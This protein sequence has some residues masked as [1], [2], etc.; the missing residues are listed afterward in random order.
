MIPH[1]PWTIKDSRDPYVDP[2]IKV[3]LDAV[4][5]PDGKD[6]QHVVVTMK[7][8]V[9]VLALDDDN[10]VYLTSEFH[11]GVGRYSLEAVSGGI[12]PGEDADLTAQRELQEEIG[13]AAKNW[14]YVTTVDP[15]TTIVVSPTRLY[16]AT[17]LADAP[18]NPEGT[19]LIETVKMPLDEAIAKVNCGE[20]SHAPTC[21]ILMHAKLKQLQS[22]LVSS[23]Q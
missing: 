8:G 22:M 3:R 12:E 18:K 23:S 11:Y 10:N 9:C 21:V 4:I 5:R 20:I 1:G 17:G 7:P 13:L 14:E 2:F 15:F 16:I 6:G 19:E